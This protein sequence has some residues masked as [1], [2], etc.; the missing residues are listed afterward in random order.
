MSY[1]NEPGLASPHCS[2]TSWGQS[3]H[4]DEGRSRKA[5]TETISQLAFLWQQ[6]EGCIFTAAHTTSRA[7]TPVTAIIPAWYSF[8][9]ALTQLTSLSPSSARTVLSGWGWSAPVWDPLPQH[10]PENLWCWAQDSAVPASSSH[11]CTHART[12]SF[13]LILTT[14]ISILPGRR[15]KLKEPSSVGSTA[16]RGQG[17][18]GLLESETGRF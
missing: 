8:W 13:L 5:A 14:V 6:I 15:R 1:R 10:H 4:K 7:G 17:R 9:A 18:G 16:G 11:A 3:P 2:V 12:T